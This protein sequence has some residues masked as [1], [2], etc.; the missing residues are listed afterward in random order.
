MTRVGV[1][2][3]RRDGEWRGLGELGKRG[4]EGKESSVA[5]PSRVLARA[6]EI[7]APL[8]A[9]LGLRL[10]APPPLRP[11]ADLGKYPPPGTF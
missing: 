9:V 4:S 1:G 3:V 11:R 6:P 8:P 5:A 7:R 2:E 10:S